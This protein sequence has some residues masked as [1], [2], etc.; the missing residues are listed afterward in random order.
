MSAASHHNNLVL[1]GQA[2]KTHM[3]MLV[4]AQR[5]IVTQIVNALWYISNIEIRP[6]SG[7]HRDTLN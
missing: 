5:K 1:W 3:T 6:Q 7:H 2:V 4:V